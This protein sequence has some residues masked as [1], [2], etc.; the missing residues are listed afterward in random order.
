MLFDS[1]NPATDERLAQVPATTPVEREA[2]LRRAAAAAGG[3]GARD[4]TER[5]ALLDKVAAVLTENRDTYAR[6]IT[7]E[8]GKPITEARA[9]VE[10]CALAC[11]HYAAHGAQYLACETVALGGPAGRVVFLPLGV[12]LAIM[13]WNF[14]FW[15]VFRFLAA[16]LIAGNTAILKHA[17]NVPRTALAIADVLKRAGAEDGVFQTLLVPSAAI[18]PVIEDPRIAA[19]TLTGSGAAGRAVA[20][21]AGRALKKTVLELGGSDAFIVRPDAD[22]DRAAAA[23]VA[24]RYQNAGQ[25]CIAAKRM[26]LVGDIAE[27]FLER[28]LDGVAQLKTGN[29]LAEDTTIGPLARAD[30]RAVLHAQVTDSIAA[31][32]RVRA[33]CALPA[34]PGCFY[35]PSVLD[36]VRPGMR[37][38]H[39]ELFGP[40]AIILRARD[41]AHA[42]HLANDNPY[43]LGGSVWTRDV[44]TGERMARALA[45]GS[46]FINAMVRSDPRLPFGGIKASG[47]GREL[48]AYGPREF[49]NIK[50][51]WIE[52]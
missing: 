32:A 24:S 41:D 19:V 9:E 2:M 37:A 46:V 5:A 22:L 12:I 11:R 3:F 1:I 40:V 6:L 14:P 17:A 33:G 51:L 38:Y 20:A 43:G 21:A 30:L 49:V 45:C 50:S 27:P 10:K 15:Q 23:A 25:S 31:G 8:M 16:A 42:V 28:F 18:A 35:P 36:G 52:P 48:A 7:E 34:G 44:V 13:P 39:E 4:I 47:Y 29:P 26:I